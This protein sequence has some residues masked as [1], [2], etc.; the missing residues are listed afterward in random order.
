MKSINPA[1]LHQPVGYTHVVETGPG[2]T[3]Y[4]S[5]QVAL[6]A[7]GRLVGAGDLKAQAEQAFRNLRAAL[8][9]AGAS[10]EQV[11]KITVFMV[12]LSQIQAFREVRNRYFSAAL[13]ASTLVQVGRLARP[14]FLIEI[15][16]VAVL[17]DRA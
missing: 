3:L 8:A 9:S 14:E 5:G 2:R 17:E 10:F 11:A 16:A 15:E 7:E 13:P 12:D 4:V 6:D 1:A